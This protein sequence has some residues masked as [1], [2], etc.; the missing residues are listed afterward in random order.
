M[1]KNLTLPR[2]V[3]LFVLLHVLTVFSLIAK[4]KQYRFEHLGKGS[5]LS[6]SSVISIIQDRYGFLWFGSNR[7][8]IRYDG[9][10]FRPFRNNLDDPDSLSDSRVQVVFEDSKGY[11]WLGTPNGLNRYD[12]RTEKFTRF[13]HDPKN[14]ASLPGNDISSIVEDR[15]Q[16]I[17]VLVKSG[18]I[19]KLDQTTG[20]FQKI[21]FDP[22]RPSFKKITVIYVDRQGTI[23]A[24]ADGLYRFEKDRFKKFKPTDPD[25]APVQGDLIRSIHEGHSG[26]L[27]TGSFNGFLNV[28]S[29]DYKRLSFYRVKHKDEKNQKE[30]NLTSILEDK[31]GELWVSSYLLGLMRLDRDAGTFQRY[32]NDKNNPFSIASDNIGVIH[33]DS[34]GVIRIGTWY[35]GIDVVDREA[36]KFKIYKHI[37]DNSNSLNSDNIA[38]IY[39][40]KDGVV[41][42]GTD[43]KEMNL[44][45]RKSKTF[46]LL[47]PKK[48]VG[49][50]MD[51]TTIIDMVEGR[52]GTMYFSAWGRGFYVYNRKSREFKH[53]WHNPKNPKSIAENWSRDLYYDSA[54]NLWVGTVEGLD[55]FDP[56][57]ETFIHFQ[58]DKNNSESIGEGEITF[59][60]ED[61]QGRLWITLTTGGLSVMNPKTKTFKTYKHDSE[62]SSSLG[63][64]AT[65]YIHI[66]GK[67]TLWIATARGISRMDIQKE[68]FTNYGEKEG[69]PPGR[70]V[71]LLEDD[72]GN[73]WGTNDKPY[74]F[75]FDPVQESVRIYDP[76]ESSASFYIHPA[77]RTDDGE[78]FFAGY[79]GGVTTFYPKK[80][81]D[82]PYIPPVVITNFSIFNKPVPIGGEKSPLKQAIHL[83]DSL[84]LSYKDIVFS[85]EFAALNYRMPEKNRYAYRMEGVEEQW[86]YVGSDRRFVTYTG[87]PPGYYTFH[88]KGSNNDGVWNEKGAAIKIWIVPPFWQ[89]WWFYLFSLMFLTGTL[90]LLYRWRVNYLETQKERLEKQVV[91]RTQELERAKDQAEI[92]KEQAELAKELAEIANHAKSEFLARMSHEL[93]TPLNAILGFSQILQKKLELWKKSDDEPKIIQKSGEHLLM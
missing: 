89:T 12:Q 38:S 55:L 3:F 91:Q 2:T 69:I 42:V 82:N 19:I 20:A 1:N 30:V 48:R 34:R 24:G 63:S 13:M 80:M 16:N 25:S 54:G 87:L 5:E 75:R 6:Q 49:E 83:T 57:T 72:K 66:G 53:Y 27:Y 70:V 61:D 26:T 4:E 74:I 71:S 90:F 60:K 43:K 29:S 46:S 62:N 67:N 28:I 33:E 84:T 52:D 58:H 68:T 65:G 88:V 18:D 86:N 79:G 40:T 85:F 44:F 78:F 73:L 17:W 93:R 37:A 22:D 76:G 39:Q 14:S 92:A 23:W 81:K 41:W 47:K 64:D 21:V 45:D 77:F 35:K 11:L 56:K 15:Q 31:T 59:M 36:Y 7:G 10:Q 50:I 9:Y 8:V 51:F 32:R